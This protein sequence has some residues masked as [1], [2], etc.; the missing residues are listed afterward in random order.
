MRIP[1]FSVSNRRNI[2]FASCDQTKPIMIITGPNGCGKS[3][4]LDAIREDAAN[5]DHVLYVGPHRSSGRQQVRLRYLSGDR[6]SMRKVHTDRKLR[7][8]EGISIHSTSRSAWDLDETG[9]Y[10]KYAMCQIELDRQS[11]LT[12]RFDRDG[13]IN[14]HSIPDVWRPLR[15]MCASLLPHLTFEAID[16]TDRDHVRCLWNVHSAGTKV[17]IDDLS[18]GEKAIVQL[19]FPLIE[20]R[21]QALIE[22]SK[23]REHE[24]DAPSLDAELCVLLDE[25]ELHLHPNL[26]SNILN[27]LRALSSRES[28]QFILATH[29]PTIVD[30]ADS[31]ELYLLRPTELTDGITNQLIQIASTTEKLEMM[32]TVFGSTSNITAMRP[33]LVVEGR[34]TDDSSRRPS[35]SKIYELLN[36]E[37][38]RFSIVSGGSKAQCVVL[39]KSL[40]ELLAREI[41]STI[42]AIALVDRDIDTDDQDSSTTYHLP[43]SMIENFSGRS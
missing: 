4:L 39:A 34:N 22:L 20:H 10:L 24:E 32:R 17:D 1:S 30:G 41:D 38:A 9:S 16:T 6:L 12:Q 8:Y 2:R 3:T 35:D 36:E 14:R 31:D 37:F 23:G 11:A 19:F 21:I 25:P 18:S 28:T 33:I 5:T 27:Y 15:D 29:S 26:Q 40:S 43:V 13:E 42:R 7:S